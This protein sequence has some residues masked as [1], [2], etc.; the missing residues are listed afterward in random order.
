M[1]NILITQN[2]FILLNFL[3]KRYSLY[4]DIYNSR[5][6]PYVNKANKIMRYQM[7]F[8]RSKNNTLQ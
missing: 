1:Y 2:T 6:L 7:Y 8:L 3:Q 4:K 5:L